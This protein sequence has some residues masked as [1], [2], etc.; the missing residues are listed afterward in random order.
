MQKK[1]RGSL[2]GRYREA[3]K[4]VADVDVD[5]DDDATSRNTCTVWSHY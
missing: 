5:D 1:K 3:K 4:Q 2:H